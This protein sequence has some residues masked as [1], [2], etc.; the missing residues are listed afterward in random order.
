M[1]FTLFVL[2]LAITPPSA[3]SQGLDAFPDVGPVVDEVARSL[4]DGPSKRGIKPYDM[5]HFY[6]QI[7]T[8]P[9]LNASAKVAEHTIVLQYD[10]VRLMKESKGE[11]AFVIAHELGHIQ[12]GNCQ[13]RGL[14]QGLKGPA[15]QRMC[16]TT[17]DL[18]GLEYTM[19]AGY[20]PSDAAAV[21]GRLILANSASEGTVTGIVL[22][23]FKSDHPVDIDRIQRITTYA[24]TIC[25]QRPEICT[26]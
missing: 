10:L 16:E 15:L 6:I 22:G 18:I 20:N 24:N 23:R 19:A 13:E 17:A 11:L 1:R 7:A 9:G 5:P 3:A 14:R 4:V 12:D 21:M 2:L 25:T 26:H 8:N